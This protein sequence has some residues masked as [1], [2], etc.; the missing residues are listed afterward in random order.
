MLRPAW[1]AAL[2]SGVI[3]AAL[4]AP[5]AV[6]VLVAIADDE[7]VYSGR[8][9]LLFASLLTLAFCGWYFARS[10]LYVEYW[11]TPAARERFEAWRRWAPR[12]IGAAPIASLAVA[13]LRSGQAGFA[14][15]YGV[16]A[17]L[18]VTFLVWRRRW[19]CRDRARRLGWFAEM[20]PQTFHAMMAL[21]LLSIAL[22]GL[23][24]VAPVAAPQAVGPLGIIF[25]A[26]ASWI[27]FGSAVLVYPT[28]RYRLPSLVVTALL[29]A[30]LFG[31]W[32][33]NHAVRTLAPGA[34]WKRPAVGEHYR[35]WLEHRAALRADPAWAGRPYP[36]FV[37]AAEGGGIRAAY[38]T[39]A[40][41][42]ALEDRHPG[43]ACHLFAASGVSGGSLGA[44]AFA[45]SIA[46]R[47]E[48]E[49]YRCDEPPAAAATALSPQIASALGQDFLAPA[50]AGMLFPDLVQRFL[51]LGGGF[52]LP[53]RAAYLERAWEAGWRSAAGS[54]RF[55]G[56]FRGLWNSPRARYGVPSLFLNGTWVESG[57]RCLTSNLRPES[58]SFVDVDDAL[59][60]IDR[61]IRLSTAVHMSAR[62]TYLSPPGTV[63]D[64]SR[65][66]RVVD[67]GYF[68]NSGALSA[69]E[70]VSAMREACGE[71]GAACGGPPVEIHALIISNDPRH[72]ALGDAPGPVERWATRFLPES[73]APVR[74]LFMT[75]IAR[76]RHDER[77]LIETVGDRAT[78]FL[79]PAGNEDRVPLGWV[80][81]SRMRGRIDAHA[82][83]RPGLAEV[84][85]L[86]AGAP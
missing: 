1:L 25:F 78:R 50:L 65:R 11:F 69:S 21:L 18:F 35:A 13:Y 44:A 77:F 15:L 62:F 27:A 49:G 10:L 57:R 76:G 63:Y 32:N 59:A 71:D 33:D 22:L 51:P 52:A 38:W 48:R 17:T 43:F 74:A 73:L 29:L 14:L 53:D 23:F 82:A 34:D 64:G 83:D 6:D 37:V 28:H 68:E 2:L 66:R 84:G 55:A 86:L 56:E 24:L 3:V 70:I 39:A 12:I 8:H 58:S 41:L 31:T 61:P 5:Q 67:G 9:L 81:S 72:P 45:A 36:V 79:L 85:A 19:F 75:R 20:P 42:A 47:V 60:L 30:T 4:H 7:G 16:V 26:S 80:L 54:D 46:D 40:V